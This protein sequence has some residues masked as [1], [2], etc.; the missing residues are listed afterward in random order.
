MPNP[1]SKN[2][3]APLSET[4]IPKRTQGTR[5]E[6]IA[7]LRQ[8]VT[9]HP[10]LSITRN[11]YR[12][13]GKYAESVWG[14]WAGT[15]LE[16]KRQAGIELSRQQHQVERNVARHASVDHYR[17]FSD[18]RASYE[19]KYTKDNPA[20]F[21]TILVASD[22]HDKEIDPF[23]NRVLIDTARRVQ[24]DVIS[25]VGDVFDL[26]EFGKYTV[27]PREWDVIGRIK[28]A[29]DNIFSPL[30]EVAPNSQ[31]DLIE[32]NHEC[33]SKQ[34]EILTRNGWVRAEDVSM[35]DEVAS[36]GLDGEDFGYEKPLA[37]ATVLNAPCG[38]VV[39]TLKAEEV[40]VN[41]RLLARGVLTRYDEVAS[42]G[43]GHIRDFTTSVVV[44]DEPEIISGSWAS[45][46]PWIVSEGWVGPDDSDDRYIQFRD[47][48]ASQRLRLRGVA[49]AARVGYVQL[50]RKTCLTFDASQWKKL[51][52]ILLFDASLEGA[53][54][55]SLD[56]MLVLSQRQLKSV[57]QE[58]QWFCSSATNSC[59]TYKGFKHEE[60]DKLQLAL[61]LKGW[62]TVVTK[63]PHNV[64]TA[65]IFIN[66][67]DL[68]IRNSRVSFKPTA[69]Q[70]VIAIQTKRGTL[71]TRLHGVINFTG[72]CRLLKHLADASPAMRAV[73]SDLHGMTVGQLFGLDKFEVNYVAKA[74]LAAYSKAEQSRELQNNYRIYYDAVMCH[75]FPHARNMGMPG[76][77]GHHHKHIVW[78]MFNITYGAY[79]WHQ[80]GA[81]HRRSASYCEGEKW[82]TGFAL[83]HVDTHTKAT[84]IEYIPVTN[85]AVVGGKFYHREANELVTE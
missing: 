40:S 53:A 34:T 20:R 69:N 9:S 30:R 44:K 25:L 35:D 56:W 59:I 47:L 81:G 29:H 31:I 5:E 42:H 24:P 21:K 27:D 48:T 49:R 50:K 10:E 68:P 66:P 16:F 84:V 14:A 73:L 41:H 12:V 32:G 37:L 77:N 33:V 38:K 75:H 64:F 82:H 54:T 46:L 45:M 2:A 79:E 15:F 8:L 17:A 18:E 63:L 78:P 1:K 72:N 19:G 61:T 43:S 7:D 26:P 70:D 57:M 36:F 83:I 51:S 11:F 52:E 55:K 39:G 13:H 65:R 62:P 23:F 76:V 60:G 4:L 6:C 80:L 22:L 3:E 58:Y 74:N 71:V 67:N 85:F 28:F